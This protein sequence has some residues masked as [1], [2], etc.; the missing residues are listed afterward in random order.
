MMPASMPPALRGE[1]LFNEPL[2]GYTTGRDHPPGG[3]T[4]RQT[5]KI[6]VCSWGSSMI[7][8][9][10]CGSDWAAIYWSGTEASEGR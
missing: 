5:G 6:C 4:N 9:R 3:Y 10:C 8:N 2:A 7:M 1:L